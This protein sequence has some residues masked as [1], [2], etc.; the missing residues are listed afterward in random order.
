MLENLQGELS[1]VLTVLRVVRGWNQDDLARASGI[2]NT[3][4]SDYERGRKVPELKTL[5]RLVAA[6]GYPLSAV[7]SAGA[8]IHSL[9]AAS[10]LAGLAGTPA[11][12][13]DPPPSGD[14]SVAAERALDNPP[15]LQWEIE[16]LSAEFGRVVSR[17]TRVMFT[18]VGRASFVQAA[19]GDST[20][21]E[22]P[23]VAAAGNAAEKVSR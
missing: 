21:P 4:L 10:M 15:A 18:L 22:T 20:S 6:M 11:G 3:S 13:R 8:F 5:R 12:P 9:R 19:E 17:M 16:Q 23:S 7:D 14:S 1:I 2:R